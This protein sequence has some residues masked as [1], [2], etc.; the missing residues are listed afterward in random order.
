MSTVI[1]RIARFSFVSA[2]AEDNGLSS[3]LCSAASISSSIHDEI[4]DQSKRRVRP[5]C[6]RAKGERLVDSQL[7]RGSPV[8]SD[9]I[10]SAGAPQTHRRVNLTDGEVH[11]TEHGMAKK[12]V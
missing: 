10:S 8:R 3:T 12:Q 1:K 5:G 2:G 6:E 9:L 11:L 7:L 4:V